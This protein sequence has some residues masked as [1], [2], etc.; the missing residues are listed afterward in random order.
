MKETK[1]LQEL[2][3]ERSK[4]DSRIQYLLC[5]QTSYE[6]KL[7]R[8]EPL[9]DEFERV[10]EELARIPKQLRDLQCKRQ[11]VHW[12]ICNIEMGEM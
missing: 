4:L 12:R 9:S 8:V 7:K 6:G 11:P 10:V 3:L 1:E 5:L 2:R